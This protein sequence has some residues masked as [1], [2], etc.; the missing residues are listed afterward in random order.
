MAQNMISLEKHFMCTWKECYML[1][2][3]FYKCQFDKDVQLHFV[4]SYSCEANFEISRCNCG[5]VSFQFS[6]CFL[7]FEI[8]LLANKHLRL[9]YSLDTLTLM[10]WWNVLFHPH[11]IFWADINTVTSTFFWLVFVWYSFFPPYAF[12]LCICSS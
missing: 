5:F 6:S 8:L 1:Y 7:Y 11:S 2:G 4:T 9:F 10:L 3:M 12:I